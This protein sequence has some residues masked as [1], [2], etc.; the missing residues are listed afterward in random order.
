[1]NIEDLT[2]EVHHLLERE[3]VAHGFGGALALNQYVDPRATRDIDLNAFVPWARRH[4]VVP[5]FAQLG[6]TPEQPL[7]DAIPVAGI[8]LRSPDTDYVI[9]VYFAIDEHYGTMRDRL[10]HRPFGSGRERLPFFSAEDIALFKVS[11]NRDKDWVDLRYLVRDGP[12]L[13][14]DYIEAT[15]ISLRGPT[16]HPR[17][18]RLRALIAAEGEELR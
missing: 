8:R 9:D 6:F 15:L 16:M 12:P 11:L 10:V 3:G 13:D 18:A 1:V 14:I 4:E 5:V 2:I 17:I 7:D